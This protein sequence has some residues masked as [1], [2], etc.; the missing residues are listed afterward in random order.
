MKTLSPRGEQIVDAA[1]ELLSDGGLPAL[2]TKNLANAV[3]VTEPALYRHFKNK[4][5]ILAGILGRQERNMRR[6]F[7]QS[8]E[9]NESV[10][11]QIEYVYARI[12][13]NFA[14]NPAGSAVAFSE[15]IFRQD[16]Q[17][18]EHLNR[19]MNTA[20]ENIIALLASEQ[21]QHECRT[22]VPPKDLARMMMGSSR[23]LVTRWRLNNYAFNLEEQGALLWKSLRVV[24]SPA[25]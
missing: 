20:E 25:R 10:L 4:M 19:I 16:S 6:L 9:R 17:L 1:I 12:F 15:E 23:L 5:D 13:H 18:A 21:G 11:D 7:E 24:L 14:K 3:G 22:D 2:T 8:A